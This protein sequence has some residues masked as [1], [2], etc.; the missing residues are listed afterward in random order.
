MLGLVVMLH[1]AG[2]TSVLVR[3]S[4]LG[5][6]AGRLGREAQSIFGKIHR[7]FYSQPTGLF[8]PSLRIAVFQGFVMID[9]DMKGWKTEILNSLFSSD[10][11]NLV[12]LIPI[13]I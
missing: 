12:H 6:V 7:S 10:E 13:S 11:V 9:P 5:V 1:F 2:K 3:L 4:F 8:P